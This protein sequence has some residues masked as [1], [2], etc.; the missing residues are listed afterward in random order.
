MCNPCVFVCER[1]Y[2]VIELDLRIVQKLTLEYNVARI[3]MCASQC[4]KICTTTKRI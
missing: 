3:N 2:G 1:E 4:D